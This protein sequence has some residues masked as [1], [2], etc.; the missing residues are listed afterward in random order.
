VIHRLQLLF[1][2]PFSLLWRGMHSLWSMQNRERERL[3]EEIQQMRSLPELLMKRRNGYRW[4]ELERRKIRAQLRRLAGISPYLILFVSPGGFFAL[5]VL[6]WW[7][8]RCRE[9]RE[10][11]PVIERSSD[12]RNRTE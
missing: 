8:D 5:P 1:V 9:K 2:S 11:E 12:Q 10:A 7:L 4:T 6:I 3:Y